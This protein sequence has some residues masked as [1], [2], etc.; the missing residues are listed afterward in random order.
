[1]FKTEEQ[2]KQAGNKTVQKASTD[3]KSESWKETDIMQ[4]ILPKALGQRFLNFLPSHL[5]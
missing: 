5:L 2:H 1:M 3:F 4:A